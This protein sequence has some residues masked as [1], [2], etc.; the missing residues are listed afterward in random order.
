M[1]VGGD[2]DGKG[3]GDGWRFI[4]GFEGGGWGVG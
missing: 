4:Y 1:V 2:V 3:Q